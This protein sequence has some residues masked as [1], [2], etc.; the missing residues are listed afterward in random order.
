MDD[1]RAGQLVEPGRMDCV[2]ASLR[3]PREG[4]LMVRMHMASICGSDL[5]A[6]YH[7]ISSGP[8]T[9][10]PQAPGFPG[11]EGVGEVVESRDPAFRPGDQ[12]LTCPAPPES[13]AFA[14]CQTIA[15][16]LCL[17]LPA[18]DGPASHLMMAQQLGTVI[19]AL[20]QHPLDLVGKTVMVMGQGSAGMFF[21]FLLKRAGA[22]RVIVSDLSEAR[23]ATSRRMGA[24]LALRANG[25][26]VR[27]AVLEE[28]GG[29]GADYL[30]EAVGTRATL[31]QTVDLVRPGA[32]LLL[33]GLPDTGD[34][35]P[36]NY[37]DFF[38]K[39]LTAYSTFGTQREP[40]RH[41]FKLALD[42]IVRKEIDVAPLVSHVFPI[43][44]IDEA[45]RVA[46]ERSDSAL[47]VSLTF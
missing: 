22:A 29:R 37:H 45:M 43:E 11:H 16:E 21:A 44:R 33:F 12:V 6:V 10:Y 47:K 25:D 3:E 5:H 36:W 27:Q 30:V 9:A 14:D 19:F 40:E 42:L 41:S 46:N 34:P 7:G 2:R 13:F 35:V 4:E 8:I 1:M 38:R 18:Y 32:E 39:K 17:R 23:L 28:T 26:N 24:D 31:L 15:A 20:R